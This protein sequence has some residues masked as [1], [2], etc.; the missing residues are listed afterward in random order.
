MSAPEI[1][2]DDAY[3][4]PTH[5]HIDSETERLTDRETQAGDRQLHVQDLGLGRGGHGAARYRRVYL[6]PSLLV[7]CVAS[8]LY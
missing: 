5:G 2:E 1:E 4:S 8:C 6:P 7:L 3:V